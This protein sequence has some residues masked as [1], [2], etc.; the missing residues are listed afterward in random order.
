MGQISDLRKEH[1]AAETKRK[2][3]EKIMLVLGLTPS[4]RP[5]KVSKTSEDKEE[6]QQKKRERDRSA[7]S[8]E[9][10]SSTNAAAKVQPSGHLHFKEV[11]GA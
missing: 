9:H 6:Q 2:E 1:E 11:K 7:E 3:V 8:Q 10:P 4:D 5:R